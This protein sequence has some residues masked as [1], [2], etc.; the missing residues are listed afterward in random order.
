[1]TEDLLDATMTCPHK[2]A[3][4]AAGWDRR[5]VGIGKLTR[6][7]LDA[8]VALILAWGAEAGP[9]RFEI[10]MRNAERQFEA[11]AARRPYL[12][13][14][15]EADPYKVYEGQLALLKAALYAVKAAFGTYTPPDDAIAVI[16]SH[17]T[18]TEQ[19]RRDL[20]FN[21]HLQGMMEQARR[22]GGFECKRLLYQ[23]LVIGHRGPEGQDSPLTR[24]WMHSLTGQVAWCW[25][26]QD[27]AGKHRLGKEWGKVYAM[28]EH[29][30]A[31]VEEKMRSCQPQAGDPFQV[32]FPPAVEV[33]Y[34]AKMAEEWREA[35]QAAEQMAAVLIEFPGI[36]I[37]QAKNWNQCNRPGERC[38]FI[39]HCWDGDDSQLVKVADLLST[40]L[41]Q[42]EG[43]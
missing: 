11:E 43:L 14:P 20:R 31:W 4:M 33:R 12:D 34:D 8:G 1:M 10:I 21:L 2:A 40:K 15:V 32:I 7:H 25:E 5:Q 29:V 16:R 37:K 42:L 23:P 41:A 19:Q 9:E 18:W 35:N 17:G 3:M 6:K 24:C 22:P 27:A 30:G 26:W 39:E 38:S 13:L 36:A 28:P